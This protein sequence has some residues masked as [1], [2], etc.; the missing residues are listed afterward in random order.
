MNQF[1]TPRV[2][3]ANPSKFKKKVAL[4]AFVAGAVSL[5]L[6]ATGVIGTANG[7]P[8]FAGGIVAMVFAFRFWSLQV[9]SGPDGS[10]L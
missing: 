10:D 7:A 2:F 3:Q 8:F 5:T 1:T 4:V 9:R 6:A